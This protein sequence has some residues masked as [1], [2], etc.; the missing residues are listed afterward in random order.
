M[1]FFLS[2]LDGLPK[3]KRNAP[4]NRGGFNFARA[5]R[6]VRELKRR[7]R[8]WFYWPILLLR[9]LN[10]GDWWSCGYAIPNSS[11]LHIF[12]LFGGHFL[13]GDRQVG[14]L[15]AIGLVFV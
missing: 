4:S 10:G 14:K 15:R 5:V 6:T 9:R 11:A 13:L 7:L 3:P 2:L 12:H 8:L 1:M